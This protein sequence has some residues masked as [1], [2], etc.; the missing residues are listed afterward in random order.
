M[1]IDPD[2]LND[3]QRRVY[4]KVKR[5]HQAHVDGLAPLPFLLNVDGTAGTGKSFL[6][7]MLSQ[8]LRE[9]P[10]ATMRP[11]L[12]RLAPTGVAA[13][14]INGETYHSALALRPDSLVSGIFREIAPARLTALQESWG[15]VRYLIIDEKSMIGTLGLAQIDRR[16][17]QIFPAAAHPFGGLSV[18]LFG[19]FAQLPPVADTPIYSSNQGPAIGERAQ[20]KSHGRRSFLA[21]AESITLGQIMRQAAT[22]PQTLAF[23]TVLRHLRCG[24]VVADDYEV[25]R[26]RAWDQVNLADRESFKDSILLASRNSTVEQLNH[27]TLYDAGRPVLLC[28]AR[29][30]GPGAHRASD[31]EAEDLKVS[32]FLMKGAK[33][34]ITRNLWTAAGLTNGTMATVHEIGFS[35]SAQ[36]GRS[37]PDVVMLA[38]PDYRGP[39]DW[40]TASDVPLVPVV[41][42]TATWKK[43]MVTCSRT[44]YPL[45]LAYAITIHKSQGM[46][47]DKARI[48][49]GDREFA[50][51]ITFVALSRVKRLDG[52][53]TTP[54][55]LCPRPVT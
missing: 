35:P 44:Q 40:R 1:R 10:L 16:L 43:Q 17:A 32:L 8:Y 38:C 25:L 9:S 23:K 47:L 21:F 30:S 27:N 20:A 52:I 3:D 7:D 13:F 14:N 11:I 6:I 26:T 12:R 28:P 54:H 41:P 34:M 15:H 22:D 50:A 4:D 5:H 46:T 18:L 45:K 55:C 53:V 2:A 29:H 36:P 33:V 51:G 48:D 31:D 39:T 49:L 37:L 42:V 19:D 24:Q